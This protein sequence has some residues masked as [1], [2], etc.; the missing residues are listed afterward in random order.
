MYTCY[1]QH[2]NTMYTSTY[3]VHYIARYTIFCSTESC[4]TLNGKKQ[5]L[6]GGSAIY[7]EP[8]FQHGIT[9]AASFIGIIIFNGVK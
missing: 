1:V 5:F 7:F 3:Y 8:F 2:Y 4:N 9:T 6:P